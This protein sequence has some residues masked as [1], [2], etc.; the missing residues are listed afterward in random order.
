MIIYIDLNNDNLYNFQDELRNN[1]IYFVYNY[2]KDNNKLDEFINNI[3][4]KSSKILFFSQ[5]QI[6]NKKIYASQEIT[7]DPLIRAVEEYKSLNE[8]IP[9]EYIKYQNDYIVRNIW[10]EKE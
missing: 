7:S 6:L 4:I 8:F 1:T 5:N 2:I 9:N 10:L 3:E